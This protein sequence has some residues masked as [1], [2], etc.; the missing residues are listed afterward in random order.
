MTLNEMLNQKLKNEMSLIEEWKVDSDGLVILHFRHYDK[1]ARRW[2]GWGNV[3]IV[4]N[5]LDESLI[6]NAMQVGQT[7]LVDFDGLYKRMYLEAK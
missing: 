1:E 5:I 7:L 3:K 2:V 6:F 4:K